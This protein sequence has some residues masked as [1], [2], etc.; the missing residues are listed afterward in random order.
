MRV[1]RD[2]EDDA[3]ANPH[4]TFH[5]LVTIA[6]GS[7]PLY[8]DPSYGVPAYRLSESHI[9]ESVSVAGP[10]SQFAS[11]TDA[12]AH[13]IVREVFAL[14]GTVVADPPECPHNPVAEFVSQSVPLSM[15]S[16]STVSVVVTMRNTGTVP[17]T[18]DKFI[19][20]SQ[21]PPVNSTWGGSFVPLAA[22]V[23][24]GNTYQFNFTITVP[25]VPGMYNFQW[26]MA[27]KI[28]E[29]FALEFGQ[30]ST[31]VTVNVH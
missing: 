15:T 7:D 6:G 28:S 18:A 23:P 17:W 19:L 22:T 1:G 20:L 29:S 4:F 13:V 11:G 27:E 14:D 21:N 16:G 5:A 25:A 26:R 10:P 9:D 24:P 12:T 3:P 31:N 8:F 30:P 2:T